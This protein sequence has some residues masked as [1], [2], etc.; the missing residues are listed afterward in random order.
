[1]GNSSSAAFDG[2]GNLTQGTDS[3]GQN[4]RYSHDA[5]DNLAQVTDAKSGVAQYGY[6]TPTC[7][8][9][10]GSDLLTYQSPSGETRSYGYDFNHRMVQSVD[11][12]GASTTFVYDSRG[13]LIRKTDPNGNTIQYAYDAV[14]R[15]V[16]KTFP[17]GSSTHFTYDAL[18]HQ[19]GAFNANSSLA[20]TYD[21]LNRLSSVGDS[22]LPMHADQPINKAL[23]HVD[24]TAHRTTTI[25]IS[26]N[27]NGQRTAL[28]DSLG[29]NLSYTYDRNNR[30]TSIKSATGGNVSIA[31]DALN[32]P[33]SVADS[34]GAGANY[35]FD[36]AGRLTGIS[37]GGS[38]NATARENASNIRRNVL[39]GSGAPL[40]FMYTYDHNGN[41]VSVTDATGASSYQFDA[42]NRLTSAA[43]PASNGESYAYDGAGNRLASASDGNY[44]YDKLGRL[45][46]AEGASYTY[47]RN[48]NILTRTAGNS[49][50]TYTYD[51]ENQLIGIKFPDGTT[52]TYEYDA[53]GRRVGKNVNGNVTAYF[54]DG[55]HIL[56][57]TDGTGN[58]Q[59]RYTFGPGID[60]PLMMERGGQTYFYHADRAGSIAAV[61][62]SSGNTVC[63]YVYD[64]FG[65]TQ[66][67]AGLTTPFGFTG[68][69]YDAESGL[70]YNR[71]R[72]YNPA[73]GRFL[74][75]D[76]LD[77]TGRLMIAQDQ[78]NQIT[79]M[80]PAS[81]VLTDARSLAAPQ[82]LNRYSYAANNPLVFRDPSGLGCSLA[83]AQQAIVSALG[84]D[85]HGLDQLAA[86]DPNGAAQLRN[87]LAS[88]DIQDP[89]LS[90][91]RYD[92][93]LSLN[94]AISAWGGTAPQTTNVVVQQ[95][96]NPNLYTAQ[97]TQQANG[98]ANMISNTFGG[99]STPNLAAPP[100]GAPAP[101]APQNP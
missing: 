67:C 17:D 2:N 1:L 79:L 8:C 42:L 82:Q 4:T 46:S 80:P 35:Q 28:A 32:R 25:K 53:L 39:S 3:N 99:Y 98:F 60:Q 20:F 51:F 85:Q 36:A 38:A 63:S 22:R 49:T 95:P 75:A 87:I 23:A 55:P 33:S 86:R 62:N 92:V 66:P 19:T 7:G 84:F 15:L 96:V 24:F 27:A 14:G 29:G 74:S 6:S 76:P 41:P 45:I 57:E 89:T 18:G 100:A 26:Y 12:S 94:I 21:A 88:A 81:S 37:F 90:R 48:G 40:Q 54:Y 50:T 91:A 16:S 5:L 13:D 11:A 44:T 97:Q 83:G 78:R 58:L 52:A 31:Y 77:T 70:Y 93:V 56:L 71:A 72:Y 30:P 73:T 10:S 43:R 65:H 9:N 64:S 61:T 101:G 68:R 47:D 34:N 69:E 59:A